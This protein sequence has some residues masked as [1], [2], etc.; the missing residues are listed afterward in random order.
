MDFKFL[1]RN[2]LDFVAIVSAIFLFQILHHDT[3][4]K[5]CPKFVL[6]EAMR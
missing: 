2:P 3:V 6:K 4:G 1:R 5:T